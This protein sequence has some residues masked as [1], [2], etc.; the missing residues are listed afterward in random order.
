MNDN[1]PTPNV[2]V[3]DVLTNRRIPASRVL[4]GALGDVGDDLIV[5]YT[6]KSGDVQV[7]SN[8]GYKPEL[9]YLL[10]RAKQYLLED[11]G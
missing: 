8:H 5:V 1:Q 6:D 10:E 2:V 7:C 3:A 9:L 11:R 4:V